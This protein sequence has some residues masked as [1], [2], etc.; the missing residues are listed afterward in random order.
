MP[1]D[2]FS[3]LRDTS[4]QRLSLR[5]ELFFHV[6]TARSFQEFKQ[7]TCSLL[8]DASFMGPVNFVGTKS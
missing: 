4:K 2:D 6:L 8:K 5:P 3:E 1:Y 7:G